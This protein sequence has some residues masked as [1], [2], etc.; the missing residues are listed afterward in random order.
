MSRSPIAAEG[1]AVAQML[2]RWNHDPESSESDDYGT[3][4]ESEEG[5]Y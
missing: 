1:E 2:S 3:S 4:E 5:P